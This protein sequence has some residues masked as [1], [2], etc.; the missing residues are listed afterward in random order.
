MKGGVSAEVPTTPALGDERLDSG[1]S[2][3]LLT[4]DSRSVRP[5]PTVACGTVLASSR[6]ACVGVMRPPIG[7]LLGTYQTALSRSR[8]RQAGQKRPPDEHF[9]ARRSVGAGSRVTT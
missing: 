9:W 8:A 5:E 2:D 7:S 6:G 4:L 3:A 1:D